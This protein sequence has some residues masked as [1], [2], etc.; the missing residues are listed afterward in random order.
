MIDT[1]SHIYSEEFDKDR[2]EVIKNAQNIGVENVVLCNV[3]T[4][5]VAQLEKTASEFPHFC[6]SAMGL[7]PTSVKEDYLTELQ[8]IKEHLF[9]KKYCAAGEIGIDLHWDKTF[10]NEQ[11]IVFEQQLL[12]A[13]S[14]NL[15]VIIHIR[16]S[17][18]EVFVS[19][20]KKPKDIPQGIFHCF[21]GGIQ[22]AKK[23]V[24]LGFM[25]GIGGV[26]TYKNTN[27]GQ[28][29]KQIGIEH[30][31]LETDAPY[32]APIPYRGKRNEPQMMIE[33]LKKLSE[34]FNLSEEKIDEI[35]TNSAKK[36]FSKFF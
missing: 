25:L 9:A 14:L 2:A 16:K 36:L 10:L 11:I 12:W 29:I 1:H 4:S 23:A 15:P 17:F 8:A 31:L 27:L 21:S 20:Q 22:E 26:V 6:L 32:L 28:I 35:T 33:V 24:E 18:E 30:L 3:D 19:L 5:T 7:H 34:I 13:N